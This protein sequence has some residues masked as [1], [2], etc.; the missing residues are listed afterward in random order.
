[1]KDRVNNKRLMYRAMT[2][3]Y[4]RATFKTYRSG[5]LRL[6]TELDT[7]VH[8]IETKWHHYVMYRLTFV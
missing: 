8:H 4:N 1:M 7:L 3:R 6:G 2:N 5:V